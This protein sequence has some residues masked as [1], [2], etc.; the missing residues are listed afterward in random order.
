[1]NEVPL[2]QVAFLTFSN[3]WR[4][5]LMS[6]ANA[7]ASLEQSIGSAVSYETKKNINSDG[8]DL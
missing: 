7:Q 2:E 6:Q 8:E 3:S 1:V 4:L 5:S